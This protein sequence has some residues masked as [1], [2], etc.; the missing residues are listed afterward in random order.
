MLALINLYLFPE[1]DLRLQI[2]Q[3]TGL[4]CVLDKLLGCNLGSFF[5][6]LIKRY[7]IVK[8]TL[9]GDIGNGFRGLFEIVAEFI[10]GLFNPVGIDEVVKT[11][12][13]VFVDYLG[14]MV[15]GNIEHIGDIVEA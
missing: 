13:K 1:K 15:S 2:R 7:P 9:V 14:G 11:H 8:S 12:I 6:C 4:G 5:K 10:F 3:E